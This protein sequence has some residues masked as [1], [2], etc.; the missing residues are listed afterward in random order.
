MFFILWFGLVCVIVMFCLMVALADLVVWFVRFG[1]FVAWLFRVALCIRFYLDLIG[2]FDLVV[3][4]VVCYGWLGITGCYWLVLNSAGV[5]VYY[6]VCVVELCCLCL[7]V[8][9]LIVCGWYFDSLLCLVV[10][11]I[12][13]HF[14]WLVISYW[15][16][17]L[18]VRYL[19]LFG[20]LLLIVLFI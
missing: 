13:L 15:L 14:M 3:W 9:L 8:E 2:F 20:L 18:F 17:R 12:D 4:I 6:V 7:V 19:F 10:I 11:L 16:L 5:D 1:Y